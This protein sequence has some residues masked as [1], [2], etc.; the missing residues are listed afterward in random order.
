[1]TTDSESPRPAAIAL[2]LSGGGLRATFYHLGVIA[3]LR[4]TGLLTRITEVYSVSGG[5]ITAGHLALNWSRYTGTHEEFEAACEE[6]RSVGDWDIRNRVLRRWALGSLFLMPYWARFGRTEILQEQYERLFGRKTL[7]NCAEANPT[8]PAFHILATSF[9]TGDLCSFSDDRFVIHS[10]NTTDRGETVSA[11]P[12]SYAAD[13][14]RISLAIAASSAFPPLFPP[15]Q[16][17]WDKIGATTEGAFNK[18]ALTDGGVYD[19]LGYEKFAA[20]HRKPDKQAVDTIIISDAGGAFNASIRNDFSAILARNVRATDILMRRT[21]RATLS[22]ALAM[23]KT[24]LVLYAPITQTVEWAP[25]IVTTQSRLQN[26]RTDLDR[27]S[28]EEI[29]LLTEHGRC[30]MLDT[31]ADAKL[32]ACPSPSVAA[33]ADPDPETTEELARHGSLTRLALADPFDWTTY[34]LV[35]AAS[36]LM[37]IAWTSS[38]YLVTEFKELLSQGESLA[39]AKQ[40]HRDK[41]IDLENQIASLKLTNEEHK[42]A[43]LGALVAARGGALPA[44]MGAG[45]E[46]GQMKP[47]GSTSAAGPDS[48]SASASAPASSPSSFDRSIY[49]VWL[50]FAGTLTRDQMKAFGRQL[51]ND[52]KWTV[53]GGEQGGERTS[54]ADGYN[55]VRYRSDDE[56]P[57]AQA[58]A[59]DIN[60]LAIALK[61]VVPKQASRIGR[62]SL[63]VWIS[64]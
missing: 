36:V 50:Q 20:L 1:M 3:A 30:V 43:L 40:E 23:A 17:T 26:V 24:H 32:I 33:P 41:Q 27:F 6:L 53:P 34:G 64:R 14:I 10:E 63:E 5:S 56:K 39:K 15:L 45:S 62:R 60:G 59:N 21:A 48:S 37:A 49:T 19:N 58:L 9:N 28:N 7:R 38:N 16:L 52:K 42:K 55:E 35:L 44:G 61:T 12:T 29:S 54:N 51:I 4:E 22:G 18:I 47:M 13:N 2:C 11:E 31:M 8:S 25:T 46:A 57:A